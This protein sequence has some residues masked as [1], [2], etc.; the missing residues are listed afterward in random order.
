MR[1]PIDWPGHMKLLT[2]YGRLAVGQ[3]VRWERTTYAPTNDLPAN[4]RIGYRNHPQ[5]E[6]ATEC[7]LEEI[8]HTESG[9]ACQLRLAIGARQVQ[10][11]ID[12]YGHAWGG[13]GSC[14]T[15]LAQ[16]PKQLSLLRRH[17]CSAT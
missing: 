10:W 3:R 13:L 17:S 8:R 12:A 4:S 9:V 15:V 1:P 16:P 11:G 5:V 6:L 14:I 2:R 7:L